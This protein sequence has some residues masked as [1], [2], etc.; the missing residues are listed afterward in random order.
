MIT[1]T[2]KAI[3]KRRPCEDGW[4]I[5]LSHLG[6][7][8]ADDEPLSLVTILDSNGLDYAIWCLRAVEGHDREIRL[9]AVWCVR[10][11]QHLLTDSRS[12]AA[13]DVAEAYANG[14]AT[15]E[16]L[17]AA[18]RAALDAVE[19]Y[20]NG[21]ASIEQL[22]AAR[23]AA[24]D[25]ARVAAGD[26]VWNVARAAR[27]MWATARAPSW[28]PS[29]AAAWD[30]ARAAQAEQFRIT[31]GPQTRRGTRTVTDRDALAREMAKE[32]GWV[33]SG[34]HA[35]VACSTVAMHYVAAAR[36]EAF[37]AGYMRAVEDANKAWEAQPGGHK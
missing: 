1:T 35:I 7:N 25:A 30:D 2:L 19:A 22:L 27:P 34:S 23:V 16:Q 13:L 31:F 12:L 28:A 11:V 8:R 20:A 3:R 36:A 4:K 18:R 17:Q 14:E 21:E 6:K 37:A 32:A 9:Y 33:D 24:G 15:A 26:A 10:Q 5:L 29:W